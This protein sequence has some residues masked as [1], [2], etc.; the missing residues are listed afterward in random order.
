MV[1][2]AEVV[3]KEVGAMVYVLLGLLRRTMLIE[4][5]DLTIQLPHGQTSIYY[6][7]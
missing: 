3:G 5:S 6:S 2:V 7:N 1:V 4:M